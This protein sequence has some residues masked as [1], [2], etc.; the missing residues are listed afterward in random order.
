MAKNKKNQNAAD[1]KKRIKAAIARG[2]DPA[3]MKAKQ[4]ADYLAGL[5]AGYLS[6]LEMAYLDCSGIIQ[7][8]IDNAEDKLGDLILPLSCFVEIAKKR[9]EDINKSTRRG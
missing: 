1:C 9:V 5:E 7:K 6:G 3:R 8:I 2:E 4:K